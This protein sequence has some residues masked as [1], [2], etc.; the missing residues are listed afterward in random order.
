MLSLQEDRAATKFFCKM[1][2]T[3]KDNRCRHCKVASE[4]TEHVLGGYTGFL[5]HLYKTRHDS[6]VQSIV[7]KLISW[8]KLGKKVTRL[9]E[10]FGSRIKNEKLEIKV[11][12]RVNLNKVSP[13][14]FPNVVVVD[15]EQKKVS[16]IEIAYARPSSINSRITEKMAKYK[17]VASKYRSLHRDFKIYVVPIV[18]GMH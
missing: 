13:Y 16:I 11:D 7:N 9:D 14:N 6:F 3:A 1:I 18:L 10:L 15:H 17:Q 4:T 5:R 12:C 2:G 8:F